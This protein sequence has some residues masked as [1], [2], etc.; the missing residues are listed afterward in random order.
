MGATA[1][2]ERRGSEEHSC[3][4]KRTGGLQ[5][6]LHEELKKPLD[7]SDVL[8]LQ[9]AREE[10]SRLRFLVLS[11]NQHHV[12]NDNSVEE[13]SVKMIEDVIIPAT[14]VTKIAKY[15]VVFRI[16]RPLEHLGLS[17]EEF[18]LERERQGGSMFTDKDFPPKEVS[19]KT[20]VSSIVW[21]RASEEGWTLF[22]HGI[23][24]HDVV[25]GALGDCY[26][27]S[28]LSCLAEDPQRVKKL[29]IMNEIQKGSIGVRLCLNGKWQAILID[30]FFPFDER[31][32]EFA[33]ANPSK[34]AGIWA[35]ALEKAW[36]KVNASYG[37]IAGGDAGNAMQILTGCFV[38]RFGV[39]D[40]L[41]LW[42][43][44]Q[45]AERR[46]FL[47]TGTI[48]DHPD[49]LQRAAGL[50]EMHAYSILGVKELE[51]SNGS[52]VKL[53]RVRNPWGSFEWKGDWSDNSQ[54][55]TP[56][57][58]KAAG[59]KDEEDGIFFIELRDFTKIFSAVHICRTR[60]DAV[61]VSTESIGFCKPSMNAVSERNILNPHRRACVKMNV[62][63][64]GRY[65]FGIH[66]REKRSMPED[67]PAKDDDFAAVRFWINKVG[68]END[69]KLVASSAYML[70]EDVFIDDQ[71]LEEGEYFIFVLGTG[72]DGDR[73]TPFRLSANGDHKVDLTVLHEEANQTKPHHEGWQNVSEKMVEIYKTW[74]FQQGKETTM[75]EWNEPE[76]HLHQWSTSSEGVA[77]LLYRNEGS[78][79]LQET[80]NMQV[81]NL[82]IVH[83]SSN[84]SI[85]GLQAE[86]TVKPGEEAHILLEQQEAD[87]GFRY[88]YNRSFRFIRS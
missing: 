30:D 87:D 32:G 40:P 8:D 84:V 86:I 20:N 2:F 49:D 55:W 79:T 11:A 18:M 53:L 46:N 28:S 12:E 51:L 78:Q 27:L 7:A 62:S 17:M 19:L 38:E 80:I 85:N 58:K 24:P 3:G 23:S 45:R 9:M 44:L 73:I 25:Q 36:A 47:M 13:K 4:K 31:T 37:A 88:S 14:P 41:L 66:Q 61:H 68:P 75:S 59:F 50:V 35:C 74:T 60:P 10:L 52:T 67:D 72:I 5:S 57:L 82:A 56:A 42:N 26:W 81:Q 65:T 70:A 54:L 64:K 71:E 34:G 63:R 39:E 1:S 22:G 16:G 21:K 29:F 69:F 48:Y 33:F 83:S 76:I 15:P 43:A 77:C 6:F